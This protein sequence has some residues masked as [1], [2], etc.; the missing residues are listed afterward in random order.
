MRIGNSELNN[1]WESDP[2]ASDRYLFHYIAN[3]RQELLLMKLGDT[4]FRSMSNASL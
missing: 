3:L 2:R 4:S 1:F